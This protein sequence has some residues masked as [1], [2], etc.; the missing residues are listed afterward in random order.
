MTNFDIEQVERIIT[1]E[2]E[3]ENIGEHKGMKHAPAV[4]F[5]DQNGKMV[6]H[7][8]GTLND[9]DKEK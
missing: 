2:E 1:S 6:A 3:M 4:V 9:L 7:K 5:H 8:P